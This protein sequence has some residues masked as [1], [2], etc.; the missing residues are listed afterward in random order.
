MAQTGLQRTIMDP[1][2]PYVGTIFGGL[3]PGQMIVIHGTVHPDADR[4]QIDFQRGNSVQPRSDVAFHFNPRFKGSGHIVCNTLENEKWGW[5]EK[6]YQM[7]FT[8][9]QPFE[10][11]FLVFHDKFQV[12]SNGKN[13]LV[14][15]HRIS[16][17]RVDTL[18]ISG[19]VKINT[20]GFLAQP[21]LL[22]SQPTSL[23]GNSIEANKGGS[24]KPRNFTIPYTGCLPSPLIPGKTM[25]IKGE[26]L[27]NAKRFAI[28]LKP[29]G[30]KDIALHLNPRMKERVFVR[31]TYLRESWGEEEKQLL[32]FPFCPEMYF[33]ILIYCDLQ[34]F[35]VAVNGVHLLEY[36]HRFK[37][38]NKINEV[39]VNGDIQLHD[40]RIW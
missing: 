27:K 15:K 17:Q 29:H 35:R 37:D 31:N 9:G 22:G 32:D 28:D 36:K 26:V 39:S 23:A 1:V 14:Y 5:E 18:G 11:I 25:V 38:L 30:S 20:I 19:K 12:S 8:K 16:L 4:F 13:L 7:P 40:V 24:E 2:V 34:Q 10:I 6:T 3:E 33:E 21:T